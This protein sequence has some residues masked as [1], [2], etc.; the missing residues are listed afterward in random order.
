MKQ[1]K[2]STEKP[3][4]KKSQE[5]TKEPV[6]DRGIFEE[7]KGSGKWYIR[8][9]DSPVFAVGTPVIPQAPRHSVFRH[10]PRLWPPRFRIVMKISDSLVH[11]PDQ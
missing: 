9:T 5:P 3:L 8:Y 2:E 6:R 4:K 11:H 7:I 10:H 1:G